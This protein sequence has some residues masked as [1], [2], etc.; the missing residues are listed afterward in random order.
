MTTTAPP[1]ALAQLKKLDQ[2]RRLAQQEQRSPTRRMDALIE[3]CIVQGMTATA[4]AELLGMTG[5]GVALLLR[6]VR[7]KY[8]LAARPWPQQS[9][10]AVARM[11]RPYKRLAN[12]K[13]GMEELKVK[14]KAERTAYLASRSPEAS[15]EITRRMGQLIEH[16]AREGYTAAQLAEKLNVSV[17]SIAKW[18]RQAKN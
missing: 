4:A 16:L 6:D 2:Q 13:G 3:L 1:A 5:E 11:P 14:A 9:P 10:E 12:Q 8:K 18:K 7:R 15:R 17:A